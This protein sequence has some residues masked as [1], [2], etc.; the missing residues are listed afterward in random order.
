MRILLDTHIALWA[1]AGAPQLSA[2]AA[3]LINDPANDILVSAGAIW[4][5]AI[6]HMR[7]NLNVHPQNAR[8]AFRLAGMEELPVTGDHAQALASLPVY[9]DHSDPFD[10]IMVAQALHEGLSLLSADQK[11]WRYHAEQIL[12]G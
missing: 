12:H 5:I 1:A 3:A 11:I 7:G 9:G 6:K 4:E 8:A 10:R 2:R